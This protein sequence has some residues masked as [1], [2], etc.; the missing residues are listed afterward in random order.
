MTFFME[1]R[2]GDEGD[3][4]R[5]FIVGDIAVRHSRGRIG[6]GDEAAGPERRHRG[7]LDK[8]TFVEVSDRGP[9]NHN[10]ILYEIVKGKIRIVDAV[11]INSDFTK[12][13]PII[14]YTRTSDIKEQ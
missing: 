2:V 14:R 3:S 4:C 12:N 6:A 1:R 7:V 9:G 11:R 10:I 8:G 13:P 5:Y